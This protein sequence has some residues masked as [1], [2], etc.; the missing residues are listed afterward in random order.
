M[1]KGAKKSLREWRITLIRQKGE[2]I[3]MVD[4]PDAEAAIKIAIEE[5]GITDPQRQRRLVA[6]PIE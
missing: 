5:F 2:Y 1:A 3:G 6:Q 4:A